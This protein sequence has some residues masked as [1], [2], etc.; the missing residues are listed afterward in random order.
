MLRPLS[1]VR[2]HWLVLRLMLGRFCLQLQQIIARIASRAVRV[3]HHIVFLTVHHI[4]AVIGLC[5]YA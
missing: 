5:D 4:I 1:K 2:L 3:R